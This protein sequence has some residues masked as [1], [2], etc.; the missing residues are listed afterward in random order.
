M[1]VSY[2]SIPVGALCS[3]QPVGKCGVP[4]GGLYVDLS[5]AGFRSREEDKRL[6]RENYRDIGNE[7]LMDNRRI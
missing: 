7:A 4:A 6:F 2:M 1:K 3:L 5:I